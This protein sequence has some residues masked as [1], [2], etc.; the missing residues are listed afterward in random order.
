MP[1][2]VDNLKPPSIIVLPQ[3]AA[4]L[5]VASMIQ[6]IDPSMDLRYNLAWSFPVLEH[7]PQRLGRSAALDA[8]ARVVIAAHCSHCIS[9]RRVSPDLL[10]DYA[11]ALTQLRLALDDIVTA[12][13]L[14]TL[15]A[16]KLLLVSQVGLAR[17]CCD[18]RSE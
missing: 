1:A 12:Q 3:A 17:Y 5:L 7:V 2:G 4:D 15:C 11:R 6:T 14:E 13:S 18:V 10:V 9:R 16:I 8:A